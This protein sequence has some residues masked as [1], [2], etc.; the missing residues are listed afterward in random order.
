[1]KL[2][3]IYSGKAEKCKKTDITYKK[4]DNKVFPPGVNDAAMPQ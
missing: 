4:P 1:M 2:P 3:N